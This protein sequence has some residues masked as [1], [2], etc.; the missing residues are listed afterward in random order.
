MYPTK[1]YKDKKNSLF[2]Y[3][4]L[5]QN[6]AFIVLV[7]DENITK[8]LYCYLFYYNG[9]NATKFA[10]PKSFANLEEHDNINTYPKLFINPNIKNRMNINTSYPLVNFV[11][12]FS[13]LIMI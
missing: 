4:N 5:I 13:I 6:V 1:K 9:Y 3:E 11:W 8:A 7:I 12:V 10:F 2:V